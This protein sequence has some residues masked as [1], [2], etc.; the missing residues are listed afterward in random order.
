MTSMSDFRHALQGCSCSQDEV[1][2]TEEDVS[3]TSRRR[4]EELEA[5]EQA[6]LEERLKAAEERNRALQLH[7]ASVQQG[8]RQVQQ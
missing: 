4:L 7:N 5:A 1:G 3:E 6:D 2:P 8:L